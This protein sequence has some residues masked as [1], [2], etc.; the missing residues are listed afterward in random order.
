MTWKLKR[1]KQCD[2][3]PWKISTNPHD[4]PNGYDVKKHKSLEHTIAKGLS[5]SASTL[6]C[7]ACHETDNA[8]CIGWIMNQLGV[9]NNIPL[10]LSMLDCEN[11]DFIRTFG[12]QHKQFKDTLPKG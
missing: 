1:T 8:H 5:F 6:R 2:K 4:I 9:G 3:C 7:M 10:R 11:A 12:E